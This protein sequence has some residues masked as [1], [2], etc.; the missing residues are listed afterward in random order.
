VILRG[1]ADRIPHWEGL[2]SRHRKYLIKNGN[3][4]LVCRFLRPG[5]LKSVVG[6]TVAPRSARAGGVSNRSAEMTG[7]VGATDSTA[8]VRP[9]AWG[10]RKIRDDRREALS[11]LVR[12][13]KGFDSTLLVYPLELP[14][15]IQHSMSSSW[16]GPR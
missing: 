11:A 13:A 2:R 10:S 12:N 6:Q 7:T 16:V 1:H 3:P 9:S 14:R 8:T 4:G 5:L 15:T